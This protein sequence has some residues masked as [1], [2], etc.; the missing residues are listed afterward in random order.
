MCFSPRPNKRFGMT[1]LRPGRR[2]TDLR[3]PLTVDDGR[4]LNE[5][6]VWAPDPATRHSILVENPA[7][8]YG[9]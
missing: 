8:L 3:P 9:V 6:A 5:L 1:A 4:V 2:P 7:R